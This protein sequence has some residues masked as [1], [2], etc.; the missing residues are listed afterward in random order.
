LPPFTIRVTPP[1]ARH[2]R[3]AQT[4]W[5]ENRPAA[6][7][8]LHDELRRAFDLLVHQPRAGVPYRGPSIRRIMLIETRYALFYRIRPRALRIDI[9]ALWHGSRGVSPRLL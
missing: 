1:A 6:P 9:L 5:L 4:W 3:D 7:L 8:A 2:I